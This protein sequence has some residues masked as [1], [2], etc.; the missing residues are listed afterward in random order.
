MSER[1]HLQRPAR[2]ADFARLGRVCRL[3]LATRGNTHLTSD[4][5]LA[6]IDRGVNY[7]NWC[8]YADGMSQA[9]RELGPRRRDVFLAVQF[10]AR[11]A[12]PA[13]RELDELLTECGTDYFD[14]VTYYYVEHRDEW[15]QIHAPGGAAETLEVA[16]QGGVVRSIGV[17]THQRPLAAEM[18]RSG[19]LDMLMVRYNAA[20]RGVEREVFPVCRELGLPVVTYTGLRWG[21]LLR[22]T[23]ED[24]PDFEPPGAAEWYRFVLAHPDVTVGLMAP[25]DRSELEED[26]SLLEEWR[27]F[28]PQ[29]YA[30][31]AAHGDRVRRHGGAFP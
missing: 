11:S 25:N 8:G 28:D 3:G 22:P 14:V 18:A 5:V 24:P 29:R 1:E 10:N 4:D 6:A 26:L 15:E 27:G 30:E 17:T 9:M 23:P 16:R 2:E 7:L 21:A 19:R 12:E 20:H 13:R 31:L